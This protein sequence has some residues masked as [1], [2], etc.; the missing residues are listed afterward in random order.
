MGPARQARQPPPPFTLLCTH[1]VFRSWGWSR[2]PGGLTGLEGWAEPSLAQ[3][4]SFGLDCQGLLCALLLS[5]AWGSWPRQSHRLSSL[6]MGGNGECHPW[7]NSVSSSTFS[8]PSQHTAHPFSPLSSFSYFSFPFLPASHHRG[9]PCLS[10]PPFTT[11]SSPHSLTL[12]LF[13]FS[14]A[15][16]SINPCSSP[17]LEGSPIPQ[18]PTPHS[19]FSIWWEGQ[20]GSPDL[21]GP[22]LPWGWGRGCTGRLP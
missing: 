11:P 9:F 1:G 8:S 20:G 15:P 21:R 16:H 2:I 13:L 5:L 6:R 4:L 3:S 19:L 18:H 7:T 10:S 14:F 12:L 22:V 17:S